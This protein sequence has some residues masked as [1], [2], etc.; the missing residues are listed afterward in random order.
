[1]KNERFHFSAINLVTALV[2][3][4]TNGLSTK[5]S[6]AFFLFV[7]LCHKP[8]T[9]ES[10]QKGVPQGVLSKGV[11]SWNHPLFPMGC[12]KWWRLLVATLG[13]PTVPQKRV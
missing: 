8:Q 1:M 7:S 6:R 5:K 10:E 3:T 9:Q 13:T 2:H 4:K 12:R 11:L